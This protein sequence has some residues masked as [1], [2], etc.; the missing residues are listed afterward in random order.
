VRGTVQGVGF[1]PYVFR[2]AEE[3]RLAGWVLNDE[4]GVL[5]E[6]EGDDAAL[7]RFAARLPS[8]VPPL[9]SVESVR[10]EPAAP[11]GEDGFRIVES[12]RA[13]EPE[14]LVSPDTATCA[15]C[16]A[17][18]LDPADRRHRYPFTNCTN[19]G[20]R[21][22]IVRGV[23]YDRPLTTMAGFEMCAACRAEYEDP[24][25]RR[26]HAQPNACPDCGPRV[27]LA[28]RDGST[29]VGHS[30]DR[31][32]IETAAK[33]LRA[34][35]IL[36]IKGIGGFHLACVAGDAA[37]VTALRSRKRR[38]HKPFAVMAPTLDVARELVALSAAEEA[39]LAGPER[40]IV[41][42]RRRR[43]IPVAAAVAPRCRDLGVMLP[44]SPLHHLLLADVAEPVVMTSG[45]IADEPIAYRDPEALDRL[46]GIADA[47]V[48]G[49]RPIHTRVDDSV[50]RSLAREASPA[51]LLIRRSRGY[52]PR[53]T[54]LALAAPRPI[55]GCGAELK[56]TFC[57]AKGRRAWVGHHI[58]DLRN[59]E[60]LRSF[61]EG[62][63][64][65]E[66]LFAVEPAV[67]AHDLHPDY[68]ATRY[69]LE[70]EGVEAVAVQHHHAHLGACL[71]EHGEAGDAVGAI[72]DG[73]GFGPDAT[74][75]GGEI[76]AGGLAEFERAGLL[77][78]V[79]LPGGDAAVREP[80][81]MACAWLCAAMESERP[82]VPT[83]LRDSVAGEAWEVVSGLTRSGLNSPLTTSAGRLFDAVAALCGV[84]AT[85]AYEGQAAAELEAMSSPA[86]RHAYPLPA[87]E[88]SGEESVVA[89][90]SMILD[91]RETL[92]AIVA[93]LERGVEPDRVGAR[94]HNALGRA[95]A[96]ACA[97]EAER[98]GL[99][100]VV[101][102]GGV[103]QN[104]LLLE[105]TVERL[106]QARLTA[107]VPMR[108]PPNDGG[109]A[110]GQV[111]VAAARERRE[112]RT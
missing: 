10:A 96:D 17:E 55:L 65:F 99:E 63:E 33:L 35:R 87:I 112:A 34:G 28:D 15:D 64:R 21:L 68:M 32:A 36:A 105:R 69:A 51:P 38:E 85:I 77:F 23:P 43:D 50:V 13:G 47:F 57:L 89:E 79:R 53:S 106:R 19:C 22:T 1:R 52:A 86:E 11:R 102:S 25:D 39:L 56:N 18:L 72:Y 61:A 46:G 14:A 104:R 109:I 2:L 37:A 49:D 7:E 31:D 62:I 48:F 94:F 98:R 54:D 41:I 6:V 107:L 67:V 9:A 93:D 26:F 3:L 30:A 103:F 60:T 88:A 8:E 92:R 82:P 78:P 40:P 24:R 29:L 75:W 80:W 20:P 97:V 73:G 76:L 110:Y 4:R 81:R 58:G 12:E 70:R 42:A 71:A 100:R 84:R 27:R 83:G 16:L 59:F 66:Q 101:L 95:T 74:V 90:G 108:L 44:Y 45:N 91:P 5:V 111:A